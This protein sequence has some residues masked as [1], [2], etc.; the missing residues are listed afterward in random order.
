[1][2]DEIVKYFTGAI[3]TSEDLNTSDMMP[4]SQKQQG[5]DLGKRSRFNV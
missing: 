4:M 3:N 5:G 1:M 2:A